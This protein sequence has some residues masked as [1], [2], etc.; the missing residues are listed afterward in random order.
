MA[1][2][3]GADLAAIRADIARLGRLIERAKVD[4]SATRSESVVKNV[5]DALRSD[6]DDEAGAE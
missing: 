6:M 1:T 2:W 5:A 4:L 3:E